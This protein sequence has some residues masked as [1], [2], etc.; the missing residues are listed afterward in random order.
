MFALMETYY[1][2]V[3]REAFDADL[4]EKNWVIHLIDPAG[5]A[6][7][8]FSTQMLLEQ[9]A[10]GRPVRALFSGDTIIHRDHWGTNPLARVWGQF[11]LSLI[12]AHP[13]DELVWFLITKGYKTYRFLPLFFREFYPRRGVSTPGW[14]SAII[15]AAAGSKYPRRYDPAAGVIRAGRFACRLRGG[16]ADVTPGRLRDPHVRFFAS[17]NP[18]HA[19]G[20]ELCCIA[21]LTRENFTPAAYRVIGPNA[22][23]LVAQS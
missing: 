11:A 16:V 19:R 23:A 15:D 7:R 1:D 8:G 4:D 18:G 12:D 21:P 6:I 17:R 10:D 14:A 20:D 3:R 9:E 5:G 2:H 13:P 22:A